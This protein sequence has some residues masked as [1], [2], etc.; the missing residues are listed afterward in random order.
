MSERVAPECGC[1]TEGR[2]RRGMC[3]KHYT[4]WVRST[5]P[6]E[7]APRGWKR[8]RDFS[9]FVD[10][11]PEHGGCW[12]WTGGTNRKGYGWFGGHGQRGLAHRLSLN[13]VEPCPDPALFACHHCDNPPCVNPAHL[14]WG[15]V[16]DNVRDMIERRGAPGKGVY[17][18]VCK[19]G[20]RIEGDNLR[21]WGKD[22][23]RVCHECANRRSREYQRRLREGLAS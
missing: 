22:R 4:R 14:Y 18:E 19:Y 15:T 5:P 2:I 23:K 7:R 20:H 11:S 9:E 10:K 1:T 6:D 3:E 17:A 16:V 21:I 13:E 8:G 12:V